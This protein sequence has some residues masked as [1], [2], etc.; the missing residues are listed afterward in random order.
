M[1][2]VGPCEGGDALGIGAEV[3]GVVGHQGKQ[4]ALGTNLG[5]VLRRERRKR[6][7]A[8]LL[9]LWLRLGRPGGRGPVVVGGV[10]GRLVLGLPGGRGT[11]LVRRLLHGRRADL[12]LRGL[13]VKAKPGGHLLGVAVEQIGVLKRREDLRELVKGRQAKARAREVELLELLLDHELDE[14]AG[15]LELL[16]HGVGA[17]LL[18]KLVGVLSAGQHHAGE[19]GLGALDVAHG[20]LG[21][22]LAGSVAVEHADD[23]LGEARER[24]DVLERKR[25]AEGGDR[26]GEARLVHGD[27]VHVALGDDGVAARGDALLGVVEGEHVL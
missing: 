1:A 7:A 24:A 9:G 4:V 26:V 19:R 14:R 17:V 18:Q 5:A 15:A 13:E 21:G 2:R 16:G 10:V 6:D 3:V 12:G 22:V 20:G 27:D 23:R 11:A 8:R 25:G